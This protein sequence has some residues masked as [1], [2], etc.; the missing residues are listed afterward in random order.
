MATGTR[1]P[2]HYPPC[3]PEG[4]SDYLWLLSVTVAIAIC[5]VAVWFV[6]TRPRGRDSVRVDFDHHKGREMGERFVNK[7]R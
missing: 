7:D 6:L 4:M 1:L 2:F 3:Y 5:V